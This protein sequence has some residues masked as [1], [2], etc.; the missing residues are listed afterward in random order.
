MR[1]PRYLTKSRFKMAVECPTKLFYTNKPRTYKDA[2]KDNDFL[3]M[4]AD[5]GYQVGAL[6]KFYYPNSVEIGC[7]QNEMAEKL[8]KQYLLQEN[9][10]LIEPAIQ[11][12]N[13]FIRIDILVKRGNSFE[14]IEVKAKSYN[15][16]EPKIEDTKGKISSGMLP[17]MQDIA[18]Q[19]F[20]LRQAYPLAEIKSFLMMPDK[21]MV[22]PIDGI[23]QMFKIGKDKKVVLRIPSDVDARALADRLL[24]KLPVDKYVDQILGSELEFPG[25]Q[26]DFAGTAL[27]WAEDY[28]NDVKIEP[29]I[30]AHCGS[31]QFKTSKEDTFKSGFKECWKARANLTDADFDKGIVL[32]LWNFRKKTALIKNGKYRLSQVERE[33]LGDF[34]N[35]AEIDGLT[36]PQRQWLQVN[37]LPED[38]PHDGFY[39]NDA[40]ATNVMSHW[41]YP[42][43]LI[44]F[45]TAAVALP[46][47]SNMHPY[48][49]VAFQF[50]HHIMEADGSVRHAGQFLCVDPGEFPNYK[51][52]RELRHQLMNDNGSVF[53]WSHHENTILSS[54]LKQLANEAN[55]PS[56]A[57]ELMSF[58]ESLIKEGGRA[59]IDLCKLAEKAFYHPDTK[60]SNSIKKVLPAVLKCSKKLQERYSQ[61]IYGAP[62]GIPSFNFSSNKG[63]TWLTIK[64]G[65]VCDPYVILKEYAQGMLPNGVDDEEGN[66]SIISAGGAAATAYARLQFEDLTEES[67]ERIKSALLRYC[68]LDTLA[69]VMVLQA[70]Q[71]QMSQLL[72]K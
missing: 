10:T 3:E 71:D 53:M 24:R 59:M 26:G 60:G 52:A 14:V 61:P 5:G 19:T 67:R 72:Q 57:D 47:Y 45:E 11:V 28:S 55:K 40:L 31:C 37:G 56:D 36:R 63:F 35:E 39:L 68:E 54:I 4:L 22:S 66:T 46:F 43:H 33:D 30:G 27:K 34:E 38:N 48:E 51:F 8:T 32:D 62:D 15:S 64:D 20:V 49:S 18:F 16:N 65:F 1:T 2:N 50:S 41:K 12:G 17:Y 29:V 13:F 9:V 44:D 58:I 6:A 42:F 70:W 7:S 69:M 21:A 25:G 23:N